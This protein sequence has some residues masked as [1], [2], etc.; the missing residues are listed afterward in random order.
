MT[1]VIS[2][3]V[4]TTLERSLELAGNIMV[5]GWSVAGLSEAFPKRVMDNH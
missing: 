3:N 4:A 1:A 5:G 2:Y